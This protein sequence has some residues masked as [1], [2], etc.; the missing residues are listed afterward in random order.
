MNLLYLANVVVAEV[1]GDYYWHWTHDQEIGKALVAAGATVIAALIAIT[2]VALTARKTTQQMELS[3]QG[4]PP[5][6]TRYKEWLEVSEKYKE[7]VNSTNVHILGKSLSEYQEIESSRE[8]ALKRA[9]WERKVLSACPNVRGQKRLLNV[10]AN[11]VVHGNKE[12]SSLPNFR[13]GKYLWLEA[14]LVVPAFVGMCIVMVML[15][16]SFI[17]HLLSGDEDFIGSTISF[18]FNFLL[19]LYGLS[20]WVNAAEATRINLSGEQFAE[21]GYLRILRENLPSDKFEEL[22]KSSSS[23]INNSQRCFFA[24]W[25]DNYRNFVYCP[26]WVEGKFA[27]ILEPIIFGLPYWVINLGHEKRGYD[28]GEYKSEV[29]KIKKKLIDENMNVADDKGA[30]QGKPEEYSNKSKGGVDTVDI[31]IRLSK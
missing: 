17:I 8:E 5:E 26:K 23:K 28:Y 25:D 31:H 11:L 12:I 4:T 1:G 14:L 29:F 19:C 24:L 21:Y 16:V 22:F 20:F 27:F 15:T 6:L 9:I 18:V 10:S 3:K 2:G 7:L 30:V 13:Y